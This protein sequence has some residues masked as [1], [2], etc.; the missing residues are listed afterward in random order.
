MKNSRYIRILWLLLIISSLSVQGQSSAVQLMSAS[1]CHGTIET[2][3]LGNQLNGVAS[4]SL[5]LLFDSAAL[6]FD[7]IHAIHPSMGGGIHGLQGNRFVFAW[8]S[9]TAVNLSDTLFVLR[10]LPKSGTGQWPLNFDTATQGQ[11]ELANL[12]GQ[13]LSVQFVSGTAARLGATAPLP[14][15]PLQLQ[16][17]VDSVVSIQWQNTA[18]MQ[19]AVL[20]W[21]RDERFEQGVQTALLSGNV[22]YLSL[23]SMQPLLGDS[24]MHWRLG[25]VFGVD[26]AWS[27]TGRLALATSLAPSHTLGSLRIYPNP[28]STELL[29][30]F[31]PLLPHENVAVRITDLAGRNLCEA[32][33]SIDAGPMRWQ[34]PC[35][36]PD[37]LLLLHWQAGRQTGSQRILKK[38]H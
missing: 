29:L 4:V 31:D 26:T 34:I 17:V 8:F 5:R 21:S 11:C 6:E 25:G 18:C 2:P 36:L 7:G 38:P 15:T 27:P 35:E 14:L 23:G 16:R 30:D 22:H 28:F 3:V 32:H 9:L 19:Q 33:L 10:W 20:Q 37:G 24:V 13:P 12:Q 1:V